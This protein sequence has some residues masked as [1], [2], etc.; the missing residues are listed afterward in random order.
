[1]VTG[2]KTTGAEA[3]ISTAAQSARPAVPRLLGDRKVELAFRRRGMSGAQLGTKPDVRSQS[4]GRTIGP[5]ARRCLQVNPEG[6]KV[7]P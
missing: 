1:M 6:V 3:W 5:G 7:A 2:S 4:C